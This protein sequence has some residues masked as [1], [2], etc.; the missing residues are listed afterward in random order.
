MKSEKLINIYWSLIFTIDGLDGLHRY[1]DG[2]INRL[3]VVYTVSS[4]PLPM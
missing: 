1:F 4:V 2:D 3:N